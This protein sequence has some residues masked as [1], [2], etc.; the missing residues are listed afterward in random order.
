M[1]EN[2][3]HPNGTAFPTLSSLVGAFRR[4]SFASRSG[5]S[6]LRKP[7]ASGKL[8]TLLPEFYLLSS[9]AVT[10]EALPTGF[11]LIPGCEDKGPKPKGIKAPAVGL[12]I[13]SR[14][15]AEGTVQAAVSTSGRA[16]L[17]SNIFLLSPIS[18]IF[19]LSSD[20]SLSLFFSM[21]S[22]ACAVPQRC[23]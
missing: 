9:S 3:S 4:R 8:Q 10:S 17:A 18:V 13:A 2:K 5:K 23:P 15:G 21:R 6:A 19:F 12:S 11:H 20:V 16:E 22:P 1:S 7:S 14:R